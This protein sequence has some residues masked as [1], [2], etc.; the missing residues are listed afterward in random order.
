[1]CSADLEIIAPFNFQETLVDG[2][3]EPVNDPDV[4]QH[5]IEPNSVLK[6]VSPKRMGQPPTLTILASFFDCF[7]MLSKSKNISISPVCVL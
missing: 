1:L 7:S 5:V 4:R 3:R 6:V 2:L